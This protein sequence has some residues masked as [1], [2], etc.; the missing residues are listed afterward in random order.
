MQRPDGRAW[1]EL[2]PIALE[3]GVNAWAEG[4]CLI[5][6]GRTRVMATVSV[7]EKVPPFLRGLG[8]G[9]VTAEYGMLPRATLERTP[10]EAARGRQQGRT[11]EIQRLIGRAL[12]A[13]V[14]LKAVGERTF[15]VD[16]DVLQ[17]DGGTRAAAVSAGFLALVEA[18]WKMHQTQPFPRPPVPDWLAAI[19]VGWDG[20][21]PR[22]DLNYAEDAQMAVDLNVVMNGRGQFAE[23]QG[24]GEQQVFD[25][26]Q[27]DAMLALAAQ[28]IRT[29]IA[30][31]REAFPEGGAVIAHSAANDLGQP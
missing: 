3:V 20:T 28:G 30:K 23:I 26:A 15:L 6:M 10:R 19:S 24:A 7:E 4:S 29:V 1:D 5:A 17:A 22:L 31:Q 25:R 2:R 8:Q 13:A 27:L 21:G 12:R 18:L 11:V 9:W 14:D 16:C